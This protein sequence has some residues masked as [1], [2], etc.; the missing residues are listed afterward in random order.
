[1]AKKIAIL[2]VGLYFIAPDPG[3]RLSAA[4]DVTDW[5]I[6]HNTKYGYEI[7]YPGEFDLWPTGPAGERP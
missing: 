6:Y 1:M 4:T 3:Q 2:L 5:Q 7:R